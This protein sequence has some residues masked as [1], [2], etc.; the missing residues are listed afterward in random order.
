MQFVSICPRQGG[1]QLYTESS[2]QDKLAHAYDTAMQTQTSQLCE[3]TL[4]PGAMRLDVT[5]H[6]SPCGRV[7]QTTGRPQFNSRVSASSG[8]RDVG[9]FARDVPTEVT[10]AQTRRT[11]EWRL[12][13]QPD[14]SAYCQYRTITIPPF[15]ASASPPTPPPDQSQVSA[16]HTSND[17]AFWWHYCQAT[18]DQ[19]QERG[20]LNSALHAVSGWAPCNKKQTD[21]LEEGRRVAP[22]APPAMESTVGIVPCT[23]KFVP[24]THGTQFATQHVH[25]T[26]SSQFASRMRLLR[27]QPCTQAECDALAQRDASAPDCCVCME[28]LHECD[29]A[30]DMPCSHGDQMHAMCLRHCEEY[31]VLRCPVCRAEKRIAGSS[32]FSGGR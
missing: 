12:C 27:R 19:M 17:E 8:Y 28:P 23:I 7:Y 30:K 10:V 25:A 31:G 24:D 18:V 26:T 15:V 4:R 5:V 3:L 22:C 29:H 2:D 9:R 21:A 1:Y 14:D 20:A 16:P 13:T 6:I 11:K 32:S